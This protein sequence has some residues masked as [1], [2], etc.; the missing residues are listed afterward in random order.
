MY[1]IDD[2]DKT[3]IVFDKATMEQLA[4]QMNAAMEKMKEQLVEAAAGA[5]RADRADDGKPRMPATT[6]SGR[7]EAVDTGKSDKVDGRACRIWDIKRN[8]ELDEQLCVVPYASLPGKENFQAVFANFAKVFEE[9]AKSVPMLAGM[10]TNEFNAQAK[11]NG[12][13]V[14]SRAY[15]NGKLGDQRAAREGVARGSRFPRRCSRFPRATSEED[16]HG[17]RRDRSAM[18]YT[19]YYAALGVERGATA[20]E[21]KKAYR[22]LAQKYHPDVSKEPDAEAKFK[23]VAEAYQT[24]KD[25]EKRAAY[26]ALGRR[27]QGEEFRPPPD[28]ARQHG[29]GGEQ[30]SFDDV[31]FARSVLALRRTRGASGRSG[32]R[33]GP[34][35]RSAGRDQHRGCVSRHDARA[36]SLDARIRRLRPAAPRAAHREGAHRAGRGRWPAPAPARQGRQ[37]IE[38]RPGRRP[39]PRHLAEAA[40]RCIAPTGHDLYLD[41]P[42]A[43]LGSRARR[44]G[45]GADTRRAR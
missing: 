15:E 18:K 4:N 23:E 20:D 10:M 24:L 34:G 28:W 9:M 27:P 8:G 26:D 17:G 16:A 19:D 21:I 42:L 22:R 38:R 30:F 12:F 44:V 39:L 6:R 40:S 2:S 45:R 14:R 43:P 7:V 33:A 13:P 31:D 35:L 37:G 41:L 3:Y 11:V 25:P 36:Q 32:R 29:S 1:I 5:A